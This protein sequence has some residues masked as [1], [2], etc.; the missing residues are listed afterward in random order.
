MLLRS[1]EQTKTK[2]PWSY[3]GPDFI[4]ESYTN[5]KLIYLFTCLHQERKSQDSLGSP[6]LSQSIR[7]TEHGT[8]RILVNHLQT[9][10]TL[11]VHV[12]RW[13]FMTLPGVYFSMYL[14]FFGSCIC[15]PGLGIS[16]KSFYVLSPVHVLLVLPLLFFP[17]SSSC[18][19][20]R[21]LQVSFPLV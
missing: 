18:L 13:N 8:D 16:Q 7:I 14:L 20:P 1:L 19:F 10:Y 21:F 11:K 3:H 2:G 9:T 5:T 17:V 6:V 12:Q 4:R 15:I